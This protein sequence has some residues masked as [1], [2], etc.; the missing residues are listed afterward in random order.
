[1]PAQAAAPR[2][3]ANDHAARGSALE[4]T[5]RLV[6]YDTT[7]RHSNLGLIETVRDHFLTKGLKPHLS[8]NPQQ[9][10]ANLF[11]TV[12]AANGDTNG[13]IVL[14]GHTD[15]VPV[16][17]QDWST[18]PF[19]PVIR[20]GKL[21]G[22]GT[23]DM[24]GFIGTSLSLLP[25]ILD[26]KLREPVHYALSFDEEIGCMGAPYL[27]AE[28]R[29]RGVTPGGCI[30]GEPT[31]MRVI[32]AHKGINAY[33]CCVKGQ[34]AHSSLTPRGVNAIEYAARLICFIRDIADEFKANGPYDQAFDV[35][36]TTAQ[37]GT[38]QGGI[39]LNTIPALCEFVF[40]FRN[41]PGVDPEAIY[42][43]IHAYAN[44][45]LLPKMRAEHA[46]AG[47]TLSKIAAAPSLDVAE[48]AAITQLVRALTA[49]RDTN[50]VAY[51]TE[52]GLFQRAGIPAV[53]CGPGDI[54]QAHKPDEFVALEQLAACEGFLHKVV[55]SLRV[56]A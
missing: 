32:V 37:T 29:E 5:Q 19:R 9:D 23:C 51:G 8:Y 53:V 10:K 36:Y 39:A 44:D 2:Q 43:R 22:R 11:V 40:E 15:V 31:S 46:D 21:Y 24:K 14:S 25:T 33:R 1:M 6:A 7:S 28:L 47:L 42:A 27:L 13:G 48:Q 41:L 16:D 3:T 35:P 56:T 34:A 50:K 45:V 54:Q 49:D 18:D 26:A 20:D 12:P 38:I 30:V 4:W 55:D 17:G 52:A